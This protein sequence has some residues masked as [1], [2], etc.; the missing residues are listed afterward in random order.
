MPEYAPGAQL[1]HAEAPVAADEYA[2][3]A[4]AEQTVAPV[5]AEYVPLTHEVH[6]PNEPV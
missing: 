4:Q 5:S 3:T 6:T 1:A 2:P